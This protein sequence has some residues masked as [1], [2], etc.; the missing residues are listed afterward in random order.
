M[1]MES[2]SNDRMIAM[3]MREGFSAA[4]L[5]DVGDIVVDPMFRPF[6]EENLCGHYGANYTCPPD[7]GTVEE[8]EAR[9][10]SYPRA[11]VFQTKW[12][13][14][15]YT[16]KAAIGEAKRFHNEAMLRVIDQ[17]KQAGYD[18]LMAGASCCILCDR[19]AL[20]DGLPCRFPD[21]KWSCLSAYCIFVRKLAEAC[22]MEYACS[23]GSLAFFGLYAFV[24]K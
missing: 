8:M 19:C 24:D 9:L 14:T 15:D 16:D 21:R 1:G 20:R 11:L 6:C 17:L 2:F 22:G 18:G 10:R 12:P 23:D 4:A 7:C 5:V 13:I 3:A